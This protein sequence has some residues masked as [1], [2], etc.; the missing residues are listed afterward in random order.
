MIRV[1]AG[2]LLEQAASRLTK[3]QPH[4]IDAARRLHVR[5]DV[6]WT[7]LSAVESVDDSVGDSD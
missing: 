3:Y 5:S 2:L 7:R 6:S 1:A 4:A